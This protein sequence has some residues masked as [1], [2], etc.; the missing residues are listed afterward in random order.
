MLRHINTENLRMSILFSTF[1]KE[2]ISN[3]N[4]NR[5]GMKTTKKWVVT[6]TYGSDN[7]EYSREEFDDLYSA[8]NYIERSMREDAIEGEERTYHCNINGERYV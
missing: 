5:S 7:R 4:Q 2:K 6:E 8:L 3:N 1:V